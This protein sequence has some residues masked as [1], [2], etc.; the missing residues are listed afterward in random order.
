MDNQSLSFVQFIPPLVVAAILVFACYVF[1][2]KYVLVSRS[3]ASELQKLARTVR[4]MTEGDENMR[5]VGIGK[6]FQNTP[7]EFTWKDF[8]KTL[9]A[10][11]AIQ[12]GVLRQK[13]SRITVPAGHFFSVA[14]VIDRPLRVDYFKH[15]P[16]ILTGIGIIGTFAGLLF[17]LSHFDASNA[18]TMQLSINLLIQGVRDAFYASAAAI[19]AAM[20]ITHWEKLQYQRCLAALDSLVE[21]I[22]SSFEAG[23]G[24]E[25]L[26]ALVK[27]TATAGDGPR[28]LKDDIIQAMV[29][30][31][32][33][34]EAMQSSQSHGL[35]EAVEHAM[36]EANRRLASQFETALIRQVKT[37][38]DDLSKRW[39][40]PA[41]PVQKINSENLAQ[42]II[43]ARKPE[44]QESTEGTV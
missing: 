6:V 4:S 5:K 41:A 26:A 16:G 14:A 39:S 23:V 1:Y 35:A 9:H 10:Q 13:R 19:T 30:I 27:N 42:K 36:N 18:Q 29:P 24:E 33:Q 21:A 17:G 37:P 44:G 43:R 22:D 32:K 20:V 34:F 11:T 40:G 25:Y 8:A 31:V 15:L 38:L 3:L 2:T 12:D 28:G 7:L